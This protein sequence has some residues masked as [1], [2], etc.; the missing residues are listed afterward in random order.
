MKRT[1]ILLTAVAAAMLA[2]SCNKHVEHRTSTTITLN[3]R[4]DWTIAYMGREDYEEEDGY[5]S[6]VERMKVECPGAEYFIIRT[7]TRDDLKDLYGSDWLTFFREEARAADFI[8][9]AEGGYPQDQLFDLLRHGSYNAFL[10][11]LDSRGKPTGD[12]AVSNITVKE[13]PATDGFKRWLG[14]WNV[15]GTKVSYDI[16]ITSLE[17]NFV[18]R[19]DGWECGED[20]DPKTGTQMSQEYLETYFE[21]ENDLMYFTSQYIQ[22]Y[23]DKDFGLREN[24]YA[25]DEMFMGCITYNGED[26]IITSEDIDIAAG[27]L[28]QDGVSGT[29][30]GIGLKVDI[31]DRT[32]IDTEITQIKYMFTP[33]WENWY[34]YN[35]NVPYLPLTLTKTGGPRASSARQASPARPHTKEYLRK[36]ALRLHNGRV[37]GASGNTVRCSPAGRRSSSA[38]LRRGQE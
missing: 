27:K 38:P 24:N 8:T 26:L 20:I 30:E 1:I 5:L 21:R 37:R 7:I 4:S 28:A 34:F 11:G 36:N 29:I 33:D 10:I 35:E 3:Q 23:E 32:T 9:D 12:Y 19:V 15:K 16:E 13:D 6:R 18:F 25:V 2:A 31:D 14:K 17:N 22:S